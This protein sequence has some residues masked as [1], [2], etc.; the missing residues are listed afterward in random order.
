LRRNGGFAV[1]FLPKA[2]AIIEL[3]THCSTTS[4]SFVSYRTTTF[5]KAFLL[6]FIAKN[7]IIV[8]ILK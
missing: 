7:E 3:Q 8:M 4:S 6:I 5:A 1:F 2:T